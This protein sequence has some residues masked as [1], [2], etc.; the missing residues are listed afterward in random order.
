VW[1][2]SQQQ[3]AAREEAAV[4][5]DPT[6]RRLEPHN[7]GIGRLFWAMREAVVVAD[8]AT[9][10]IV[11]WNPAAEGMF[12]YTAGEAVGQLVEILVPR[13]LRAQHL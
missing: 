12:G 2:E 5:I 4:A 6:R 3:S 9:G 7:L 11:L 1:G 8:A 10:R 13:N